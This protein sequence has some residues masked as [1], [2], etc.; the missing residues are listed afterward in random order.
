MDEEEKRP[1][2][3]NCYDSGTQNLL[4]FESVEETEWFQSFIQ[5]DDSL[6]KGL[7]L[8]ALLQTKDI[9]KAKE[10]AQMKKFLMMCTEARTNEIINCFL[11]TKSLF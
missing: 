1:A 2:I 9:I 11:R 10:S 7:V 4:N 5:I 6:T 3:S 8:I